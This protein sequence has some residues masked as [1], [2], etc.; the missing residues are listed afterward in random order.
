MTVATGRLLGAA[1]ALGGS[2]ADN[3]PVPKQTAE[4]KA[5]TLV[6]LTRFY[7]KL[8]SLFQWQGRTYWQPS[9][10][11]PVSTWDCRPQT[12]VAQAFELGQSDARRW[13]AVLV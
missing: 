3:A 6:L 12:T 11:V 8:P 2:Y 1:W 5:F 9:C 4:E 7:P 10:K 13:A